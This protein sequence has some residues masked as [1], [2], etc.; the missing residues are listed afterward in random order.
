MSGS[1]GIWL[2]LLDSFWVASS[3]E[4]HGSRTQQSL[5]LAPDLRGGISPA[6]GG[7]MGGDSTTPHAAASLY[8]A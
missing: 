7:P 1:I 6:L 2:H 8:L 5:R 3:V 4:P